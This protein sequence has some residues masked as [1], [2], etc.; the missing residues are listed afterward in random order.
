[1]TR[2]V[3]QRTVTALGAAV[4]GLVGPLAVT[5]AAHTPTLTGTAQ[6]DQI[7]GTGASERI[8]GRG[9]DDLIWGHGGD[10]HIRASGRVFAGAGNDTVIARGRLDVY[11]GPGSNTVTS[12]RH[13]VRIHSEGVGDS[14]RLGSGD[15]SV[16]AITRGGSARIATGAGN[17]RVYADGRSVLSLSTGPGND[18]I[19]LRNARRLAPAAVVRCGAGLDRVDLVASPVALNTIARSCEKVR[20]VD[21]NGRVL[22][23][24]RG[25]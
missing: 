15:D 4:I 24:L 1:M 9:G 2:T 14:I 16:E 22:R 13:D 25:R 23:V 17:D 20:V 18:R 8:D 21:E 6:A 11:T 3:T 10:D 5:A 12:T 19:Q 7:I